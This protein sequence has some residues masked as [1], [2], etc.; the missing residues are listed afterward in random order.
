MNLAGRIC[1]WSILTKNKRTIYFKG[2]LY[3][4][5]LQLRI[6]F[7]LGAYYMYIKS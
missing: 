1:W 3:I 5:N 7:R 4:F 6:Y 2:D